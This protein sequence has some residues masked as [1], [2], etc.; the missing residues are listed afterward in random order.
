MVEDTKLSVILTQKKLIGARLVMVSREI[1]AD[2]TKLIEELER[3]RATV[4]QATPAT[5]QMLLAA[6]WQGNKQLKVL[7]GGEALTQKLAAELLDKVGSLWNMYGPTETT[8]WSTVYQV[9]SANEKI[10]IGQP[11]ANTQIYILAANLRSQ[12]D[13][14]IPVP[15]GEVGEL[16]IGGDGVAGAT[17]CSLVGV[18][19]FGFKK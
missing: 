6:G 10:S 1:A 15:L 19:F 3:S 5:W 18:G 7:C 16:H 8:I 17:K 14:Y 13:A 12:E 9:K 2:G 4:M 11:I